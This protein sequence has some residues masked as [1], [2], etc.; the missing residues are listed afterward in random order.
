M[1]SRT[2]INEVIHINASPNKVWKTLSNLESVQDYSPGV[3]RAYYTSKYRKGIGASRHCHLRPMGELEESVIEWDEE[4][5][6]VIRITEGKKVPPF[7]NAQGDFTL[8]PVKD[9]TV[10]SLKFSYELKYGV[11]GKLMNLFMVKPQFSV[12]LKGTLLGLKK[13][14]EN[15]SERIT[16][17]NQ[18][19]VAA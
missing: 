3:K 8:Q 12:A 7:T 2:V 15:Q 1:K 10:C 9:G 5:R 13:Y 6:L 11:L 14:I 4:K 16:P 18:K 17:E 19:K